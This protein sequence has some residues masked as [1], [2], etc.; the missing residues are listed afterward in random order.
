MLSIEVE[1]SIFVKNHVY[2][3]LYGKICRIKFYI[4]NKNFTKFNYFE[5]QKKKIFLPI[6]ILKERVK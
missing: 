6:Q 3:D 5:L 4:F 2:I 1:A